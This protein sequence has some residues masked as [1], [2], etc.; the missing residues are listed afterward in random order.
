MRLTPARDPHCRRAAELPKIGSLDLTTVRAEREKNAGGLGGEF[1]L[2]T[3]E[4][5]MS[6]R[7]ASERV[8]E[9]PRTAMG[10]SD[11]L[12][13]KFFQ[14]EDFHGEGPVMLA[15]NGE[16]HAS[17]GVNGKLCLWKAQGGELLCQVTLQLP[18]DLEA[19]AKK[20]EA[21]KKHKMLAESPPKWMGFDCAGKHLGVHRPGVGMW[22][23]QVAANGEVTNALLLGDQQQSMR[24]TWV[25]F[26]STVVGSLSVG[27]S[28]GRVMI[29]SPATGKSTR[30][31]P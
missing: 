13:A 3:G 1:K 26:S 2:E 22:I 20:L 28:E 11:A 16:V 25:G 9:T 17:I 23:C 5:P 27:T 29:Y 12:S 4:I 7:A 18:P 10:R 30:I 6:P 8:L 15:S 31:A 19:K 14:A 24:Y 21:D